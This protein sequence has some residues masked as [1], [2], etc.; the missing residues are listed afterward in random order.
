MLTTNLWVQARL[1]N[2]SLGKV[3][4]IVY[5]SNEQPPTL[6]SFFV[7]K[8][9]HYK[10]PLWDSS[11]P[12]YVPISPITRGSCRQ[13]P[14]RMAWGLTIHKA[15]GMTLQNVTIDIGNID[16]QGF[17]FTAI[18]R[19]TSLS[20]LHISPAFSFSRYSRMQE[21]PYVQR[22]KQEESLL[23]SKYLKLKCG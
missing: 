20:G 17:T 16:K 11:N 4:D 1:V 15:Q 10:G 5:N 14:L 6:P 22:R 3:I 13:L 8:F 21:N 18:S 9:L 7:V 2:G 19:V 23:A 12:T